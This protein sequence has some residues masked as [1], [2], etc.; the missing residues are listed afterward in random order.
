MV[1][2]R[3]NTEQK[4][5]IAARNVFIKK[6]MDGARMQEIADEAGINKS[7]LHYYFRSKDKLFTR[8]FSD[9]F[10]GVMETINTVF[11]NSV[12][13]RDFIEKF[14]TGYTHMLI[15]KPYI[16]NFVFHELTQ[17]PQRILEYFNSTNFNRKKIIELLA[18]EDTSNIRPYDPIQL[19][20][21]ILS[22]CVFPFV[23]RPIIKGLIFEGDE[24]L[25]NNFISERTD[26][27]ID[28]VNKSVFIEN[29]QNTNSNTKNGNNI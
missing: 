27:I 9:I 14:V 17:N 11:E 12:S 4:I 7:L 25:F 16:P 15:S 8:V 21:D 20:V 10:S 19:I 6:G 29:N 2:E 22:L 1:N 28:F 24:Q 23:A 3:I 5:I 13:L 26:H 18:N